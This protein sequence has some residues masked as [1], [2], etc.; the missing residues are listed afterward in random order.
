M[1]EEYEKI[2]MKK[3]RNQW[4]IDKWFFFNFN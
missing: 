2:R 4:K 1:G 3:Y